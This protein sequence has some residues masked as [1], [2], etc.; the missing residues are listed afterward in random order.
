MDGPSAHASQLMPCV[1]RVVSLVKRWLLGTHQGAVSP[2]HPD[3]YLDEDTFLFNHRKARSRSKPF[4]RLVQQ[5]TAVASEG[6][7]VFVLKRQ[8]DGSGKIAVATLPVRAILHTSACY[9]G[10]AS[11]R[12][13]YKS[14]SFNSKRSRTVLPANLLTSCPCFQVTVCAMESP[15]CAGQLV[16]SKPLAGFPD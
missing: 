8:P 1:H 10:S 15:N 11:N 12:I 14:A 9:D 2:Q 4:Y 6:R 13:E 7:S 5:A 16:K 3:Y